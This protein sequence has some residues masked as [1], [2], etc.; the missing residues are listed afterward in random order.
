[1]VAQDGP[2]MAP[3]WPKMAQDGPKMAPD[4]PKRAFKI[5]E[6]TRETRGRTALGGQDPLGGLRPRDVHCALKDDGVRPASRVLAP[7][8][9][10]EG[11]GDVPALDVGKN[12][13][14]ALA[15]RVLAGGVGDVPALGVGVD[16]PLA[17]P[18]KTGRPWASRAPRAAVVLRALKGA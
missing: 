8:V 15:S 16:V 14:L 3:R 5:K 1:M 18:G 11:V 7:R 13:P 9:L 10:A 4:S 12:V 2:K 17:A 6:N